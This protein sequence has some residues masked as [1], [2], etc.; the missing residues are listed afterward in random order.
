MNRNYW[1]R[2]GQGGKKTEACPDCGR[3]N[4]LTKGEVEKGYHCSVCT[5]ESEGPQES[6][7]NEDVGLMEY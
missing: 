5:Y 1:Q 3:E 7:F 6:F 2:K 4:C